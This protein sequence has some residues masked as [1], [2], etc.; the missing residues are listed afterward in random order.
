MS[1][2]YL[3]I[4]K[5]DNI[6]NYIV[7]DGINRDGGWKAPDGLRAVEYTGVW[8][9]GW[10]WDGTKPYDPNPPPVVDERPILMPLTPASGVM[11][12]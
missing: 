4:D 12:M 2:T 7:W 10:K 1:D 9:T 3:L 5:N 6:I 11:A 8:Q